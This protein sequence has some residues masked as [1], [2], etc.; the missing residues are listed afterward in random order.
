MEEIKHENLETEEKKTNKL[1]E[2][3]NTF[4]LVYILVGIF[5]I[6]LLGMLLYAFIV[7]R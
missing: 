5:G 4:M 1:E 3:R 2:K 6:A 7:T